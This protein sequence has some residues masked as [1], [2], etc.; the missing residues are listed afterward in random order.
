AAL[1]SA[2]LTAFVLESAKQLEPNKADQTVAILR[3]IS[4]ALQ[5]NGA[6]N[7]VI[8]QSD[9]GS[10]AEFHPKRNAIW[11]NCL[12][13]LSLS[14]SVA[15]SL[16]AMLAKQWC[17]YYLSTRNGDTITQAEERQKRY[18]GLAK[19]R[20][21]GILEHLPMLMHVALA[22]T[23]SAVSVSA[24]CFYLGTIFLPVMDKFCPFKTTQS[25]YTRIILDDLA[26]KLASFRTQAYPVRDP[27]PGVTPTGVTNT[28]K[29]QAFFQTFL[30]PLRPVKVWVADQISR[31]RSAQERYM[32]QLSGPTVPEHPMAMPPHVIDVTPQ[33]P[34][35]T[36]SPPDSP[37]PTSS[38]EEAL[39][40]VKDAL[41]WLIFN[42]QKS[43]SIDTAIGAL[44]IG[45]VRFENEDLKHQI[46]L[47]LVKHF[48]DCFAPLREGVKLQ[49]S[50]HQ[51]A[52]KLAL[53]YVTWMTYFAGND[54][55][56]LTKQVLDFHSSLGTELW[57][58]LGLAFA[59]QVAYW[60]SS[61]ITCYT[62][63]NQYLSVEV[64][65]ILI[66]G[67]T[68]A[69][70]NV[71]SA[72]PQDRARDLVIHHLINILWKVSHVDGSVLR[73]SI[74]LNLAVFA[75]TTN[76]PYS[77]NRDTFKSAADYLAYDYDSRNDR[78]ASY[79]SFAVF[80]L[81]G[82][83]HPESK[84]GL[85]HGILGTATEIIHE[86]RYLSRPNFPIKL[87]KLAEPYLLRRR[88]TS[89]LVESMIQTPKS[90]PMPR[91]HL[92]WTAYRRTGIA[93]EWE[94][95]PFRSIMHAV[96]YLITSHLDEKAVLY[97]DAIVA[98]TD[99]LYREVQKLEG[100]DTAIIRSVAFDQAR[101]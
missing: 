101:S 17:Y 93:R 99:L 39:P 14:L 20:M 100:P 38:S 42:S 31:P 66:D 45:K 49:L 91:R 35:D 92:V 28:T 22:S 90:L 29:I 47:H 97:D 15:V 27:K 54:P 24:L 74:G 13:F 95:Q 83:V 41:E 67:L 4:R 34:S 65:S 10:D 61:F 51:N 52:L 50:H 8:D 33:E 12:W 71:D 62:E 86:T 36:A 78:N 81:L 16:A 80:A 43:S 77:I 87:P 60:L 96:H 53:D 40:F 76:L 58:R 1:F 23:V 72:T 56:K 63:N 2:I 46:N 55:L 64:L 68:I 18:S 6:Q 9:P 79:I 30:S 37:S 21:R 44:A 26:R 69:G 48:S 75:L 11:V 70:R 94:R 59:R 84:L 98:V 57:T 88:L 82:F 89:M 19:W 7:A 3:E 32:T 25:V 85:D 73:S 5:T